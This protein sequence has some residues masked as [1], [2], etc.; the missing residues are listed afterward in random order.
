[1]S[2]LFSVALIS[3][4][5]TILKT[6]D[7][8]EGILSN[9]VPVLDT[10]LNSIQLD[11]IAVEHFELM[12]K[13]SLHMTE[14]DHVQIAEEVEMRSHYFDGIVLIHGTDT[15]QITGE[16]IIGRNPSLKVPCVLTGAMRPWVMRNTDALQNLVESFAVVQLLQAG[17]YVAMQNK[18]RQF[19]GVT[20]NKEQLC[21]EK[22][23]T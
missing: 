7:E 4:G 19:P 23:H 6:Y 15:L 1:M 3:T 10:I 20:K 21:F 16:R 8:H 5:G 14:E 9:G 22:C 12:N 2:K 17:V 18:V 13:D 11:G